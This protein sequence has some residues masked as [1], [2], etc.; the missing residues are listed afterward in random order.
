MN[1]Q[2]DNFVAACERENHSIIALKIQ[3]FGGGTYGKYST[4][5]DLMAWNKS[6]WD[7]LK[8]FQGSNII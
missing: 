1:K 6:P 8:L 3:Y 2:N 5:C 7:Q 4:L